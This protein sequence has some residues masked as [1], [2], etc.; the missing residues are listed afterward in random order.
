[1][2]VFLVPSK[3][4]YLYNRSVSPSFMGRAVV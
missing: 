1:M 2:D 4:Y 3:T